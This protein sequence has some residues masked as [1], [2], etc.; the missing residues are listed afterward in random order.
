MFTIQEI[1]EIR[2]IIMSLKNNADDKGQ[3]IIFYLRHFELTQCTGIIQAL[4]SHLCE[5]MI[6][7]SKYDGDKVFH[8]ERKHLQSLGYKIHSVYNGHDKEKIRN[9]ILSYKLIATIVDCINEYFTPEE[10]KKLNTVNISHGTNTQ[11]HTYKSRRTILAYE[12]A[13]KG[14]VSK[15]NNPQEYAELAKLPPLETMHFAYVGPVNLNE[16]ERKRLLPKKELQQEL[17]DFLEKKFIKNK[18]VVAFFNDFHNNYTLS[19][20]LAL[21]GLAN[22]GQVNLIAKFVL[23][24]KT[25][26]FEN[27][28]EGLTE[29]FTIYPTSAYAPNLLRFAAD[30]IMAGFA[31]STANSAVMLGLPVI[32][33]Y[34]NNVLEFASL[35]RNTIPK[36]SDFIRYDDLLKL[37]SYKETRKFLSSFNNFALNASNAE[38]V[39]ARINDTEYWAEYKKQLPKV[40][41]ELFG[42]YIIEGATKKIAELILNVYKTGNFGDDDYISK[43]M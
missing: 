13:L 36:P 2:K 8:E 23:D 14:T 33:Y 30:F 29:H 40:Q 35:F 21:I 37:D 20:M 10:I 42:D 18:P 39:L 28:K 24:T 27:V 32:P 4:P 16:W 7:Y 26:F 43:A 6:R 1:L 34:T 9:Q 41:E 19:Q 15:K 22:S 17:E 31:G 25:D 12:K 38:D 5:V 3:K 11:A